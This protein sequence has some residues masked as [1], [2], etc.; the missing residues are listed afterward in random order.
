MAHNPDPEE[1]E[2]VLKLYE[3]DREAWD[4]LPPLVRDHAWIYRDLRDMHRPTPDPR[5]QPSD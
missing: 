3:T 1:M 2:R 5:I 4:R